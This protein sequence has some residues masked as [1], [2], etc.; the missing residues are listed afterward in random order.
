MCECYKI[1]GPFIS[2]DPDCP[3]HGIEATMYRN[4]RYE[5]EDRVSALE[6]QLKEIQE[7]IGIKKA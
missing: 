1:G 5:L 7:I 2:A 3:L 6:E 4:K